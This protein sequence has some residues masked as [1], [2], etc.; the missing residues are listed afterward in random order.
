M[1]DTRQ[2][3]ADEGLRAVTVPTHG[4]VGAGGARGGGGGVIVPTHGKGGTGGAGGGGGHQLRTE[5][6]CSWVALTFACSMRGK[7]RLMEGF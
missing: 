7:Q 5:R 6:G 4:E 3:A 2:A 1:L